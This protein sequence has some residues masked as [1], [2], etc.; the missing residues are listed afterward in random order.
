M[1]SEQLSNIF[2]ILSIV[3]G[4]AGI[5]TAHYVVG[6]PLAIF[7]FVLAAMSVE[8]SEKSLFSI[9]GFILSIIGI[10][11]FALLC[12]GSDKIVSPFGLF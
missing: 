3:L 5:V 10:A 12:I 9:I 11:W 8:N 2:A 6:G 4:L 7:G 1:F